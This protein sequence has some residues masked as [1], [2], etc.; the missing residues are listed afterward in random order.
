MLYLLRI[1]TACLKWNITLGRPKHRWED[2]PKMDLIQ[3]GFEGVEWIHLAQGRVQWQSLV[4]LIMN[5][6]FNRS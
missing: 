4:N 1:Y 2:N 3:I 5:F 6:Q